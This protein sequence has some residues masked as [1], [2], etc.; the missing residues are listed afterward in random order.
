MSIIFGKRIAPTLFGKVVSNTS[1]FPPTP[2]SPQL[3][4]KN[5]KRRIVKVKVKPFTVNKIDDTRI[6]D[7]N[8]DP[9]LTEDNI[10]HRAELTDIERLRD[11]ISW[12]NFIEKRMLKN[13]SDIA[14]LKQENKDLKKELNNARIRDIN[15]NLENDLKNA[16]SREKKLKETICKLE[17]ANKDLK[18]KDKK[19]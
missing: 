6:T 18:K 14:R 19:K 12:S 16:K 1:S 11:K 5:N 2:F 4:K 13:H 9:E 8:Q 15:N 7:I 10:N 3:E 17:R